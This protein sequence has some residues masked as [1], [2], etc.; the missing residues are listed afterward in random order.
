M[1]GR[2]GNGAAGRW[3]PIA[4]SRNVEITGAAFD[5]TR[6]TIPLEFVAACDRATR[7]PDLDDLRLRSYVQPQAAKPR[8][9]LAPAAWE[10]ARDEQG[11]VPWT[12]R[13]P[14][15]LDRRE[16]E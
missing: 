1:G 10:M 2:L 16:R 7:R 8:L 12:D 13:V 5:S 3:R 15:H 4:T 11:Q 6:P 14:P 9:F